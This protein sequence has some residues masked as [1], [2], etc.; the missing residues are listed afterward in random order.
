MDVCWCLLKKY[1]GN[2]NGTCSSVLEQWLIAATCYK[3]KW[4]KTCTHISTQFCA[5]LNTFMQLLPITVSALNELL[6]TSIKCG[7]LSVVGVESLA[8]LFM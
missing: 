3:D 5:Y 2:N 4:N 6:G 7:A 1:L 8:G